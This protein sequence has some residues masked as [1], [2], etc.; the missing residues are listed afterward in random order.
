MVIMA[1][2][3]KFKDAFALGVVVVVDDWAFLLKFEDAF[4]LGGGGG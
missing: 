4:A 1:F 2:L 3:L